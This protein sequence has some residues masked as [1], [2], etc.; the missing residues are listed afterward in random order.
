MQLLLCCCAVLL[1]CAAW[2]PLDTARGARGET[3]TEQWGHEHRLPYRQ[4][5]TFKGLVLFCRT[6][7]IF[8][9]LQHWYTD[10]VLT[11]T[12]YTTAP[13]RRRLRFILENLLAMGGQNRKKVTKETSVTPEAGR[14]LSVTAQQLKARGAITKP[15]SGSV[16]LSPPSASAT[17]QQATAAA[18]ATRSAL[19][20]E[21][22]RA[23]VAAQKTQRTAAPPPAPAPAAQAS[24]TASVDD[25]ATDSGPE[26]G[27]EGGTPA[28]AEALAEAPTEAPANDS[29]EAST[30]LSCDATARTSAHA[31]YALAVGNADDIAQMLTVVSS[32]KATVA[33]QIASLQSLLT[34]ADKTNYLMEILVSSDAAPAVPAA[35]PAAT[36]ENA[37]P[38]SGY[39]RLRLASSSSL[40]PELTVAL[41]QLRLLSMP[42][43]SRTCRVLLFCL[44]SR[45]FSRRL[46]L[47]RCRLSEASV[48]RML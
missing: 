12:A 27:E 45:R 32:L 11:C 14:V 22:L 42:I 18:A 25:D 34:T 7:V 31:A 15:P 13:S 5:S 6:T 17:K 30:S 19:L 47:H 44:Q 9:I 46:R 3:A 26:D 21:R 43:C 38:A 48:Q 1:I 40:I 39:H 23:K 29:N 2:S 35:L 28:P 20:K 33:K 24:P 37:R 8:T 4:A 10:F 36:A 16:R 41:I